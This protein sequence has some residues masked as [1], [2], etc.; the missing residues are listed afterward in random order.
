MKKSPIALI[1]IFSI[2]ADPNLQLKLGGTLATGKNQSRAIIELGNGKTTE[3]CEVGKDCSKGSC[4]CSVAGYR[5]LKIQPK[6]VTLQRGTAQF[7]L[8]LRWHKGPHTNI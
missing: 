1:V 3:V 2:T 8:T 4:D 6:K 5:V 7:T